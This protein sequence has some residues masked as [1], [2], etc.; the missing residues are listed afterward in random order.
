MAR[1][2]E[3]LLDVSRIAAGRLRL[4]REEVD[5]TAVVREMVGRFSDAAHQ[6]HSPIRLEAPERL[7]GTWDRLRI[8]QVLENLLG[9]AVK[10]G[11][12]QPIDVR[13]E[14]AGE[15]ARVVVKDQGVGI[16]PADQARIFERFE[17]AVPSQHYGGLGLGLW[18]VR[19]IVEAHGGRIRVSS[20]PSQGA[21]FTVDLPLRGQA[22][23]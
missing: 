15:G 11:R 2:V 23:S 8:E 19:Q 13:V 22:P 7:V 9:N 20:S 14:G 10:Y 3:E 6:V 12:G 5:L 16:A 4:E 17:R 18:I 1:L 21:E